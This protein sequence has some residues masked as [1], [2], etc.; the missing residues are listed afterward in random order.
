[1]GES[2]PYNG[3]SGKERDE[4]WVIQKKLRDQGQ[5]SWDD[6]ACEM[7][8]QYGGIIMPHLEDYTKPTEFHPLCVECHMCLHARFKAKDGWVRL[9]LALRNGYKPTMWTDFM[10]Y[11]KSTAN[12]EYFYKSKNIITFVPREDVWYENLALEP[13]D[14][15]NTVYA[16]KQKVYDLFNQHEQ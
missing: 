3:F 8:N 4:S 12:R 15:K 16:P 9:L 14:L 1:M 7:C 5:I 13:L 2:K 11:F 10:S 6:K